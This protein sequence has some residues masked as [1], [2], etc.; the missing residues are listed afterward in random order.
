M[1]PPRT[2][3]ADCQSVFVNELHY[4]NAGED[5]GEA[6]EIAGPAGLSLA[7]WTV[8]VYSG[9]SSGAVHVKKL[10]LPTCVCMYACVRAI[11]RDVVVWRLV[12]SVC[13]GVLLC[14]LC[15]L[16]AL[17]MKHMHKSGVHGHC[18]LLFSRVPVAL[19]NAMLAV[20]W[21]ERL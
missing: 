2:P 15:S 13:I 12:F 16:I 20:S 9:T 21:W 6:I 19:D 5:A 14:P 11:L 18:L 7:G 4:D 8:A 17:V 1:C 3:L 10:V